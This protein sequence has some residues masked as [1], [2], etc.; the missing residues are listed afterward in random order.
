MCNKL[1]ERQT[2]ER[3]QNELVTDAENLKA[4]GHKARKMEGD[5]KFEGPR[6]RKRSFVKAPG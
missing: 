4:T 3:P 5:E 1:V 6:I 2:I